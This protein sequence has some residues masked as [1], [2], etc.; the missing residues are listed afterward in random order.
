MESSET[1]RSVLC[2][3]GFTQNSLVFSKRIKVI[4]KTLEDRYNLKS[5]FPN[6]PFLLNPN[7]ESSPQEEK[8]YGWLYFDEND[9][10]L[11]AEKIIECFQ[12]DILEYKGYLTSQQTLE[13]FIACYN[14]IECIIAFSQ[15]ALVAT[16][17]LIQAIEQKTKSDFLKNLKCCL[18]ISGL[19]TPIPS[20]SELEDVKDYF[21]GKKQI[22]IPVLIVLGKKDEYVSRKQTENLMKY[23]SNYEI[24]EHEGKHFVPSKKEDLSVYIKFLDKYFKN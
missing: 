11:N 1:K 9:K 3:H 12:R 21:S 7:Q 19:G 23:Y 18:L 13:T 16:L 8:Q 2:L 4:S 10:L 22:N 14:N 6:A 20:N 5:I 15:G 17:F 24:Y